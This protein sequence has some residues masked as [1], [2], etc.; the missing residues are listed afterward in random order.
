MRSF[1]DHFQ[2]LAAVIFVSGLVPGISSG[3]EQPAEELKIS[4]RTVIPVSDQGSQRPIF[5][6]GRS[7][8]E[9]GLRLIVMTVAAAF[10]QRIVFITKGIP[11]VSHHVG[12]PRQ[13]LTIRIVDQPG[14]AGSPLIQL[15]SQLESAVQ[16]GEKQCVLPETITVSHIRAF[17]QK[18]TNAIPIPIPGGGNDFIVTAGIHFIHQ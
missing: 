17:F 18:F 3:G 14:Q 5:L 15:I 6:I 10:R 8:F 13:H 9:Q 4:F 1:P 11:A 7:P 16:N 2:Q 12:D